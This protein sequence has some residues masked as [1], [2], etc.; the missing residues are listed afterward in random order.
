MYIKSDRWGTL[1]WGHLSPA[2]DN[3]VVL[4]DISG[5]VIESNSVFFEG[6]SF[7]LRP[8]GAVLGGYGGLDN[9]LTWGN[10]LTCQGLG[11]GLGTDCFG[12]AQPAVRYD[13]P[14]WGGFSF[15]TSWGKQEAINPILGFDGG[16]PSP[17]SNF[18]DLAVM[19]TADW[20]SIKLSAAYTYTWMKAPLC[21]EFHP[22]S[23]DWSL[24]WSVGTPSMANC[25]RSAAAS[26]QPSG[27]IFGQ[28]THEKRWRIQ[29]R[30]RHRRQRL[31]WF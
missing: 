7:I 18:W 21:R 13:S 31:Y 28:Y 27:G 25:T 24:L 17:E 8:K 11:V 23:C 19:Y 2:S 16:I 14:T 9:G 10:F 30:S 12:A 26:C 3:K 15:Q 1:N 6:A 20:N 5:T 29:H 4:A 22:G